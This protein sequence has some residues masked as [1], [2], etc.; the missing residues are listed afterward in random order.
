MD[1]CGT[2]VAFDPA[3]S[4]ERDVPS[5]FKSTEDQRDGGKVDVPAENRD[6]FKFARW[7]LQG[8]RIV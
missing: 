4:T 6:V 5:R 3:E 2:E 7:N 8:R 1:E